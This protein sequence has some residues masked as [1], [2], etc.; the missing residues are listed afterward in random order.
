VGYGPRGGDARNNSNPQGFL[1]EITQDQRFDY[2]L[3]TTTKKGSGKMKKLMLTLAV[4]FSALLIV[5]LRLAGAETFPV[6]AEVPAADTAVFTVF[7]VTGDGTDPSDWTEQ[8]SGFT[9]LDFGM[10]SY[11]SG[12]GIFLADHFWV[13]DVGVNGAGNPDVTVTYTEGNNPN[14]PNPGLGGHGVISFTR[15]ETDGVTETQNPLFS[16]DFGGCSPCN[17]DETDIDGGWLRMGVGL[18]TGDP[19]LE[20]D[21][22][23]PFTAADAPGEGPDA[24]AGSFLVSAVFD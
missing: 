24:Y 6:T 11:N 9:D 1:I 7:Q 13:I 10:L 19:D 2:K 15:M 16:S 20:E 22:A 8:A 23:T 17:V 12:L 4:A 3:R 14:S 21:D 18:A 5:Q